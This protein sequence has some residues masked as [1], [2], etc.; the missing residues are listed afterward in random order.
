[1]PIARLPPCTS[2]RRTITGL[3]AL[4]LAACSS[5]ER[6]PT[7][8]AFD[9]GT[10]DA[11]VVD[12]PDGTDAT[13]ATVVDATV[14]DATVVDATVADVPD[15]PVAEVSG[16]DAP[17][18]PDAPAY[19][20][21][22]RQVGTNVEIPNDITG[23]PHAAQ[24]V[25]PAGIDGA[26]FIANSYG[27]FLR[28][29]RSA[30]GLVRTVVSEP[31]TPPSPLVYCNRLAVHASSATVYCV[32]L[33]GS[34]ITLFDASTG[35]L[36]AAVATDAR[37]RGVAVHGDG[38]YLAAVDRGLWRRPI[39]PDGSI[40]DPVR[41]AEGTFL[42][43]VEVPGG[44]A[45]VERRAGVLFVPDAGASARVPLPGPPLGVR[46]RGDALWIPLGS[47]GLAIVD[48]ATRAVRHL[49]VDCVVATVDA[50]DAAVLV[51][52]RQG[53]RLYARPDASADRLIAPLSNTRVDYAV[54]DVLALPEGIYELDWRTLRRFETTADPAAPRGVP[55][56]PLGFTIPPGQTV[57][58]EVQNP[59]STPLRAGDVTL[60]PAQRTWFTAAP[61]T[62]GFVR[63]ALDDVRFIDVGAATADGDTVFPGGPLGLPYPNAWV[64]VLQ[65]DCALQWPDVEDL[66][67]L[68]EHGGLGDGRSIEVMLLPNSAVDQFDAYRAL[69]SPLPLPNLMDLLP[70][71]DFPALDLAAA[72]R[73]L[74]LTRLLGGPDSTLFVAT[75]AARRVVT[76][77]NQYR[78]AYVLRVE[79][80]VR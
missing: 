18:A 58:Y 19:R 17:D 74:S 22:L 54:T 3:G 75:D 20:A 32:G 73:R 40:G 23:T 64:Y 67:W 43:V 63:L 36:R 46:V 61:S 65:P 35:A 48:L 5:A 34:L 31:R 29:Q 52:C 4:L 28:Y 59:L 10:T 25:I 39:R 70:L 2:W 77:A 55:E 53:T 68:R 51:G 56:A 1:M 57:R 44:V 50:T 33:L 11:P 7:S 76:M 80:A 41:V 24:L 27:G 72:I 8:I 13:D 21:V 66:L 47:Q 45:A 15:V 12:A 62:R 71:A 49:S 79:P 30:A 42:H 78:G 14:V 38:L 37:Y 6:P 60:A 69:W 16:V 9:G 26:L